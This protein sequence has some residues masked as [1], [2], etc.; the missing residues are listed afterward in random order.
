MNVVTQRLFC[1]YQLN[2]V[3]TC[4]WLDLDFKGVLEVTFEY[5]KQIARL[6]CD[7]VTFYSLVFPAVGTY[8]EIER[9]G[10]WSGGS[11]LAWKEIYSKAELNRNSTTT[12]N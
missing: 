1:L 2:G 9:G 7:M 3:F 12:D 11:L 5:I 10:I 8:R 6:V 4:S